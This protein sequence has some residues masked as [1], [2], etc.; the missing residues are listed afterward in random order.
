MKQILVRFALVA[1]AAAVPVTA[2]AQATI[3]GR[4]ANPKRSV[5][6][7]VAQCGDAYC[8]TVS[9]ATARNR[10]HGAAPGT[11]VLSDLRPQGKG[12]Y[13]G[14]AYEPKRNM[15]GSATIHQV[16]PDV[17]V[18]KGCAI[19]GLFCKQQRWTRIS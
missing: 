18:V 12:I 5:I 1:V 4:W 17:M 14:R 19:M 2:A 15:T 7:N 13:K 8:G 11:R 6:V 10:E 16:A 3:E 9:W